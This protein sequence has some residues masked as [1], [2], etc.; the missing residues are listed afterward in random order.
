VNFA[1]A[2]LVMPVFGISGGDDPAHLS[3]IALLRE[4]PY[5]FMIG[6]APAAGVCALH[7]DLARMAAAELGQ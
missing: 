1:V 3:K 5:G 7:C 2:T 6:T 4:D